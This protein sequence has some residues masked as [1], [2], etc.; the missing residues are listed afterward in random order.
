M[1]TLRF[2]KYILGLGIAG[3][4]VSNTAYAKT[5][6]S[7]TLNSSDEI[8]TFALALS[9][10]GFDFV[11]LVPQN[12]DPRWF[13]QACASG[14]KCDVLLI[15]GHF[16][17]L[18][19]GEGTSQ[20]IDIA[21]MEKASCDN[22][23]PGILKN[24]K[25]VFLMGCN[26]LASQA[27]DHRTIDQYLNVLLN[28]GIPL[29]FA[30]QVVASRYS[31]QGFSLEK[32]FAS[33]FPD[34]PKLYGFFST[35][36]LGKDAAPIL[37]RYLKNV[38]NYNTHL[39][40]MSNAP[41]SALLNAFKGQAFRETIPQKAVPP[42]ARGLYCA[43]R[44]NDKSVQSAALT[45]I[46]QE[47]KVTTYFDSLASQL[48]YGD[49]IA[50]QIDQATKQIIS[51]SL[52][53]I[54]ANNGQL[55]TIQHDVMQVASSLGLMDPVTRDFQ[56]RMLLDQAYDQN[57]N[58]AK[59]RQICGI[60]RDEPGF[61]NMT[62]TRLQELSKRSPYF[63]LTLSCY[64][65]IN[66]DTRDFLFSKIAS[67]DKEH[68][69]TIALWVMKPFWNEGDMDFL[70]MVLKTADPLLRTR[71]FISAKKVLAQY[72]YSLLNAPGLP[73]CVFNAESRTD[74]SLGKEWSCLSENQAHLSPDI[75]DYFA[76]RNP[77]PENADDMR[78]YCW[79]NNKQRFLNSRPECY[80]LAET[81]KIRG[82]QMKNIWNCS[83][84]DIYG[85]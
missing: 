41:N 81:F 15:S 3:L 26:T 25:E 35:G 16:G 63:M 58:Y 13:Q 29:D 50:G 19:F 64:S 83:N 46:A 23:C 6:C 75:C 2:I 38:G 9:K 18:F 34:T 24:P 22:S 36:P 4:F 78:W 62:F 1:K 76:E 53:K 80:L 79:S 14:I 52:A 55:V 61:Q 33:I 65:E 74:Y 44:S 32:R 49:S 30:E 10:Q 69:R 20:T 40:T 7:M 84:R 37:N 47:N 21:Q 68:E 77:D 8:N 51:K 28:D 27:R 71:L 70:S 73:A 60:I 48:S 42:E 57:M 12:K 59:V 11:E 82:N 66:S 43:L 54:K 5:F 56:V 67:P 31:Q 72:R 45:Q 17:G 85:Y 39:D